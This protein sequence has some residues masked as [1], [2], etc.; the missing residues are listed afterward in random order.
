MAH[1]I[2]VCPGQAAHRM[3]AMYSHPHAVRRR[4]ASV[5]QRTLMV[6]G[7]LLTSNCAAA[8]AP[9]AAQRTPRIG[10]L[11]P[12]NSTTLPAAV[13]GTRAVLREL[14]GQASRPKGTSMGRML[15]SSAPRPKWPGAILT[16]TAYVALVRELLRREVDVI[17]APTMYAAL[18][19][20]EVTA[21]TP[22][23]MVLNHLPDSCFVAVG[24][25]RKLR[26]GNVTGVRSVGDNQSQDSVQVLKELLPGLTRLGVIWPRVEVETCSIDEIRTQARGAGVELDALFIQ[27]PADI[28]KAFTQAARAS[29]QALLVIDLSAHPGVSHAHGRP[30]R[31][32]PPAHAARYGVQPAAGCWPTAAVSPT[33][34]TSPPTRWPSYFRGAKPSDLPLQQAVR[35]ELV[36]NEG[37]AQ[38]LGLTIPPAVRQRNPQLIP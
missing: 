10:V 9:P 6:T 38:R 1:R 17:M 18:A 12:R 23:V 25:L 29:M 15:K 16:S 36:L 26:E 33:P 28:A 20:R 2:F 21:S 8:A 24:E 13:N 22:I 37:A 5:L 35:A 34:T 30:G 3:A 7:L 14:S 19:A 32:Q 4:E 11:S 31:G 27:E